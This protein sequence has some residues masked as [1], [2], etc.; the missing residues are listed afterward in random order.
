MKVK[1][2]RE[3]NHAVINLA[4]DT[5][6][7]GKQAL[8]FV[9]S[10]RSAEKMAEDISKKIT[11]VV[12]TQLEQG[13]LKALS[14]PT[15]QC[16]RLARII[17]RGIAFHHAGLASKQ[18]HL[19]EDAFRSK[20]VN[21]ICCT[22]TLAAGLNLPAFRAIIRD[23]HRYAGRFGMRGIPVLEY[24]QMAGRAGRP[25][26]DDYGEAICIAKSE[27]E[28]EQI[29]EEYL[30]GEPEDIH[31]KLNVEPVMRTYLLSL[32]SS[33]IMQTH[34]EIIDFFKDT[35]WAHQYGDMEKLEQ[36]IVKTLNVLIEWDFIQE[37][38]NRYRSTVIGR[39]IA[40]LYLDPLT[41]H[42][43]INGI[44]RAMNVAL[45]PISFIQLVCNTN[46]MWPLLRVKNQE[47][48]EITDFVVEVESH[49]LEKEPSMFELEYED[50]LRSI[51]TSQLF[52]DWIDEKSEDELLEK[53]NV[54][55]GELK[56]KLDRAEWLLY[57]TSELSTLLG[58]HDLVKEI[59]R[60]RTRLRNGA[61]EELLALLKLKQVGR[62]RARKLFQLGAKQP[63]DIKKL[64]PQIVAAAIGSAITNKIY[65]QL[66]HET[67]THGGRLS[68]FV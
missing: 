19:I 23:L 51:K 62:V 13:A 67:H 47:Y 52:L 9:N 48:Q 26:F 31:S 4:L 68:D 58:Q 28:A 43:L 49:L 42:Q 65:K 3:T 39:R 20:D 32:I 55:P 53:Y 59:A 1:I 50:W 18:R 63:S 6:S 40:E 54:R 8:V 33:R 46:E 17:N 30:M 21:I 5:I 25:G 36:T 27:S 10:K 45:R 16:K 22:P 37:T 14:K 2:A 34:D 60:I 44:R 35:F 57:G 24:H 11:T 64:K 66:G 15:R 41:A 56:S 61:K 12:K 38:G 29:Y 7:R